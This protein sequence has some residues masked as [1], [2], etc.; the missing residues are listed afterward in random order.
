MKKGFIRLNFSKKKNFGGFTLLEVLMVTSI[1]AIMSALVFANY[2]NRN[3]QFALQRSVYKVAQDIRKASEMGMSAKE[4]E[5][6]IPKGGYG[7][8]FKESTTTYILFADCNDNRVYNSTGSA[9]SC[10]AATPG[11]PYPEKVEEIKLEKRVYIQNIEPGSSFS[12]NFKPPDPKIKITANGATTTDATTTIALETATTT[13]RTIH[14]N[15]AG[16]IDVD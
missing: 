10:E 6:T 14:V 12:I 11:Q 15:K 3:Q 1:I 8:Y 7:I 13:I 9:T 4:W 5:N 16:L 2:E